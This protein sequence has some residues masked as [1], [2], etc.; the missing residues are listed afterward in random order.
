M[1]KKG[2]EESPPTNVTGS[3]N[4]QEKMKNKNKKLTPYYGNKYYYKFTSPNAMV[5]HA[6]KTIQR[7]KMTYVMYK[8]YAPEEGTK[9]KEAPATIV[10]QVLKRKKYTMFHRK[11]FR[12]EIGKKI[13]PMGLASAGHPHVGFSTISLQ[14]GYFLGYFSTTISQGSH[15]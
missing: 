5:N 7:K 9:E 11:A 12:Y 10:Q 15:N 14:A 3:K 6:A 4:L 13:H 1:G 8:Y 2:K